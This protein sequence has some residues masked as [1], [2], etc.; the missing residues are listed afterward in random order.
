MKKYC[1]NWYDPETNVWQTPLKINKRYSPCALALL[2]DHFVVVLGDE[3]GS[4]R[5]E[6]LDLSSKAYRWISMV[7]MLV[8]RECLGVGVIDNCLYAV[9]ITYF[10]FY[11]LQ[12]VINIILIAR[13]VDLTMSVF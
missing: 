5:V 1:I 11:Y 12:I 9:N 6:V 3:Y 8:S 10:Y 7:D 2:K 13:L 4:S